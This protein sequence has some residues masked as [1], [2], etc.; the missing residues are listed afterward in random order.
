LAPFESTFGMPK[1]ILY[2][3][4]SL[5]CI[6][7]LY[8][9]GCYFF[10]TQNR[11]LYLKGIAIA[12]FL[13]CCAT[14]VLVIIHYTSLTIYGLTYFLVELFVVI[15]LVSIELRAVSNR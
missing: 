15:V 11:R 13:Y 12:N 14:I 9:L 8:S 7:C 10:V 3:L 1:D 4:T 2:L 5:A 6:L